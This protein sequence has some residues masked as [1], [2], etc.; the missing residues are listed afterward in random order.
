MTK[1]TVKIGKKK[2][3]TLLLVIAMIA[4][5]FGGFTLYSMAQGSNPIKDISNGINNA[6]N[7]GGVRYEVCIQ[8]KNG[9]WHNT[10]RNN[11]LSITDVDGI[12][13]E[14]MVI[15][16]H[17]VNTFTGTVDSWSMTGT[18]E[19]TVWQGDQYVAS[20]TPA[21]GDISGS[22]GSILSGQDVVV[23]SQILTAETLEN[24]YNGWQ[25]GQQYSMHF[26][27]GWAGEGGDHF[28]ITITLHFSDGSESKNILPE[29][30]YWDFIYHG[31]DGG[32]GTH[33]WES[34]G[35]NWNP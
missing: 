26:L 27:T 21:T 31:E 2:V 9:V 12:S 6:F 10:T 5:A 19:A 3:S 33:S 29:P 24:S 13:L 22:G 16:L 4:I 28:P 23:Y 17:M 18:K 34:V 15:N 30:F 11:A 14:Q 32:S 20:I 7:G 35:M 8:D 1:S 25:D